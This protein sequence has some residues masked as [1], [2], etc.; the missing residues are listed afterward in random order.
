MKAATQLVALSLLAPLRHERRSARGL[1]RS[2]RAVG[3]HRRRLGHERQQRQRLD[4]EA[5]AEEH[6]ERNE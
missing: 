4:D 6:V 5:S 1:L 3:E 2:D